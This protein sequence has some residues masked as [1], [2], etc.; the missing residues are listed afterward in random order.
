MENVNEL[1][2][3][4]LSGR[5]LRAA[6]AWFGWSQREASRQLGVNSITILTFEKGHRNPSIGT[7]AQIGTKMRQFGL[8][9]SPDGEL[10]LPQ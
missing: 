2:I 7:L 5:Q 1:V 8:K 6:R 10:I 4:R 9:V 3:M